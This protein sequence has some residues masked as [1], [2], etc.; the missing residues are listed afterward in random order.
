MLRVG[1]IEVKP[2]EHILMVDMHH[3]I[4]DGVSQGILIK[5]FMSF[6][7]NLELPEFKLQYKDY[8]EWQQSEKQQ[9]RISKQ[10]KY[11]L[12]EFADEVTTLE[13]ST[14]FK[15]PPVKSYEGN[16]VSFNLC[17]EETS[18]L[19]SI[20]ETEG[21]TLYMVLLSIY[22][23]LLSKLSNQEDIVVGTPIAGRGHT[24]LENM[25]GMFVN[26]LPLRNYPK[27]EL[28][29]KKFLSE[30]KSKTLACFE[31]QSYQYEELIDKLKVCI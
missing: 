12:N 7:N 3:I 21:A 13:L 27:G 16:I 20:A 18:K 10:E 19:K 14:D 24:D 5:D 25:I 15:R 4:S 29:F 6:Y 17:T 23:V 26:T 31:N 11:W 8:S 1:L 2:Q 28:S 30:V 22:N 9:E